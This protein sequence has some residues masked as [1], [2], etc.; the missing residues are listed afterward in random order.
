MNSRIIL[1]GTA[2]LKTDSRGGEERYYVSLN[3]KAQGQGIEDHIP[4]NIEEARI[5]ITKKQ[6]EEIQGEVITSDA[7]LPTIHASG[8]ITFAVNQYSFA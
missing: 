6:Y 2:E 7:E 8:E 4:V 5:P 1:K 3:L